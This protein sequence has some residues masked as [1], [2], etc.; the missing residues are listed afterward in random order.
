[1]KTGVLAISKEM[2]FKKK[3][4]MENGY[5]KLLLILMYCHQI[6]AALVIYNMVFIILHST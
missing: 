6:N 2:Y 3:I 5:I 1:M 4:K